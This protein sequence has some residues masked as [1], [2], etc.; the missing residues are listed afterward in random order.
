MKTMRRSIDRDEGP[1][2]DATRDALVR[3]GPASI[4]AV[5]GRATAIV[6]AVYCAFYGFVY[7]TRAA[8]R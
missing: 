5:A 7:L 2:S 6:I 3:R 4:F 8:F 1:T